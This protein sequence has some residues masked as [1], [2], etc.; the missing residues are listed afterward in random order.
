[1]TETDGAT[2]TGRNRRAMLSMGMFTSLASLG[3]A[4]EA[5]AA[6]PTLPKELTEPDEIFSEDFNVTFAGLEVDHKDLIY[7]LVVGQTIGFIGSTVSGFTARK[8]AK[9][10]ERLNA[11]LLKVNKEVRKELRSSQGR[12]VATPMDSTDDGSSEVVVEIISL[13]KSGK[14]KLKAQAADEAKATFTKALALIENNQSALK[15]PWKAV[16]KAERG[17]GAAASR[18]GEYEQALT[19]MKKVLALS[20]EHGDTSVATDAY[21][22]IADLYA[23]LDQIEVAS[24]WY[25]KYFESLALEDEK[26]KAEI[27]ASKVTR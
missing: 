4:R 25:D 12:K 8:R 21:G 9:E 11:T 3:G 14:S 26:E 6:Q 22:T 16:R 20:T 24:D 18:L 10:I 5:R 7:A 2:E 13:L 1:M 27:A 15:E 17:L 23:E 19:H